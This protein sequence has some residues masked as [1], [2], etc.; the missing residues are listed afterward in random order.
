[1]IKKAIIGTGVALLVAL[2]FFGR[3]LVSYVRT[4]VGYV[5][6]AVHDTVPVEFQIERA[7]GLIKGLV[8]EIRKNLHV[9]AKEQVEVER[10]EKQVADAEAKLGKAKEDIMRLKEDLAT[11]Q[12]EYTYHG[13]TYTVAQVKTDL[14][15]RFERYK[16][17]EATLGSLREI[18]DARQRSLEAARE[19]LDGMLAAR[20][21]LQV[22]VEN[23]EARL[24]MVAAAQTTSDYNFDDSKL[25]RAKELVADL[26][27]RLD[28]AEKLVDAEGHFQG[29]IPLDE[30]ATENIVEQVTDYFE[31]PEPAPQDLARH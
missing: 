15:N 1:M 21:Q 29:Q 13:R 24:K 7:R 30:P 17:S 14:A 25:A 23:L 19:K 10:L 18:Y 4:S 5:G 3:D 8:P 22:D 12:E 27:S 31:H 11:E 20:R 28:V 26:R 6:E 16:T 9:I 2:L